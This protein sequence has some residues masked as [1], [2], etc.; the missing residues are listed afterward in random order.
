MSESYQFEDGHVKPSKCSGTHWITHFLRSVSG[1]VDKFGSYLQ[2]FENVIANESM[3]TDK[4]TLDGKH[5][6]LTCKCFTTLSIFHR[7]I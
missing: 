4:G 7:H 1:L 6:Q 3:K 5:S 2:H